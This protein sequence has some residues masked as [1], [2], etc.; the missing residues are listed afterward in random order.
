M[1]AAGTR[2]TGCWYGFRRNVNHAFN[3]LARN[4]IR[5]IDFVN[6]LV[7][8]QIPHPAP[9]QSVTWSRR[10]ARRRAKSTLDWASSA[11]EYAIAVAGAMSSGA[12]DARAEDVLDPRRSRCS[13]PPYSRRGLT[14][15]RP[16]GRRQPLQ[17]Q[18]PWRHLQDVPGPRQRL[19]PKP[20]RA[21]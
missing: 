4:R 10:S 3:E 20:D 15:P 5:A 7:G 19:E 6:R 17:P 1:I 9:D 16:P 8:V 18:P 13:D 11:F 21:R 12:D 2:K 14:R